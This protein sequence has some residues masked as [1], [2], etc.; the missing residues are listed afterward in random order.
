[1]PL[2][3]GKPAP[4]SPSADILNEDFPKVFFVESPFCGIPVNPGPLL[5]FNGDD[6]GFCASPKAEFPPLLPNALL[7]LPPKG[8]T[9]VLPLVKPEP[10]PLL[11]EPFKFD[12]GVFKPELDPNVGGVLKLGLDPKADCELELP[13]SVVGGVLKL[14]SDTNADLEVTDVLPLLPN[15][16]CGVPVLPLSV[17]GASNDEPCCEGILE[18]WTAKKPSRR[19]VSHVFRVIDR[20]S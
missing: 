14:E 4:L 1:M 15:D 20:T 10:A 6:D 19:K 9:A 18:D 8:D 12:G 13:L 5:P 11:T 3:C 2:F 17:S 16:D 7:L